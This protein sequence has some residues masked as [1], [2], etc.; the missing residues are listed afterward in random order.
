MK[1]VA[2]DSKRGN[3]MYAAIS[4]DRKCVIVDPTDPKV[5]A[6]RIEEEGLRR[7]DVLYSL[8][9]HYHDDHSGGNS[10][11][12]GIFGKIKIVAG[13]NRAYCHEVCEDGD[14][15]SIGGM[16][17]YV[18]KTPCHTA[19]SLCYFVKER[20]SVPA[21]FSGDTVF[22]L[23]CGRF[24]EGTAQSM[25][26]SIERVKQVERDAIV[27]YGHDYR[28]G[29]LRFRE[30]VLG[31]NRDLNVREG[32]FLSVGEEMRY[33]LFFNLSLLDEALCKDEFSG[34]DNVKKLGL[35]RSKK[36]QFQ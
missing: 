13:S 35:L 12:E 21:L 1:V 8:T 31:S 20:N 25:Y 28:K 6:E 4:E 19:D 3:I 24:F 26:D 10:S 18:I 30:A 16:Q 36:D 33:N 23:G 11:L 7:E 32:K 2:V 27:Y 17:I 5:L 29:N 9:T 22:Y 34:K 15:I 14:E